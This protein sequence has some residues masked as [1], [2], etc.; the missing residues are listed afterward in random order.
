M[1]QSTGWGRAS[2]GTRGS[3]RSLGGGR[4][5][6]GRFD[7]DRSGGGRFDGC[8]QDGGRWGNTVGR[9]A[10]RGGRWGRPL[11]RRPLKE[12]PLGDAYE[13]DAVG[14]KSVGGGTWKGEETRYRASEGMG[15]KPSLI[16]GSA[17]ESEE[18]QERGW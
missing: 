9:D 7:R 12:K 10:V 14:R 15:G 13:G 16:K 17:G 5:E 2:A 3:R 18:E 1:L 11:G 6:G 8:R 4:W